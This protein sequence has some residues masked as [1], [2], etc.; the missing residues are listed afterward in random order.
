M[1][2]TENCKTNLQSLY[3]GINTAGK[4]KFSFSSTNSRIDLASFRRT[5]IVDK[6]IKKII[7]DGSGAIKTHL[8]P[9]KDVLSSGTFFISP[10][11][12]D[13]DGLQNSPLAKGR[14]EALP[15]RKRANVDDFDGEKISYEF[16]SVG[17]IYDSSKSRELTL[18]E[19]RFICSFSSRTIPP[20]F[21]QLL[22]TCGS[23]LAKLER[24]IPIMLK[25]SMEMENPPHPIYQFMTYSTVISVQQIVD[26]I[27]CGEENPEMD[28]IES[29]FYEM[30][31]SWFNGVLEWR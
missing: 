29:L 19:L 6:A 20:R 2:S 31:S 5:F 15:P 9:Q 14:I 18:S 11:P 10:D 24:D 26:A 3:Q 30:I 28:N 7:T 27:R 12:N 25:T 22:T 13:S 16:Y 17:E 23:N 4:K 21:L 1:E 8:D